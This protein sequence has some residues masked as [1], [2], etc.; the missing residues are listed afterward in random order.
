MP[1]KR[2]STS[3]TALYKATQAIELR[4]S[5]DE[6]LEGVLR[7]AQTL[8]EFEHAAILVFDSN[9]R[10]LVVEKALGYGDRLPQTLGR[11]FSL[12]EGLCGWAARHRRPVC[13]GD[14]T[15]D[16]R[17]LPGLEKAR[18][19][20]VIPL[21]AGKQVAGVLSVEAHRVDAF[22]SKHVKLLTVLGSQA[23]LAI[24]AWK[25]R[26]Q[27]REKVLE[28]NALFRVSQLASSHD[29]LPA[30]LQAIL[31]ISQ[32]IIPQGNCAVLLVD[33]SQECLRVKA[34]VNYRK[35]VENLVIPLG[36]GVTGRCA[37]LGEAIVVDEVSRDRDYIPGLAHAQSEIAMPLRVEGR[38]IGVLNAESTQSGAFGETQIRIL[39][40]IAQQAAVVLRTAQL[41]EETRRL[42]ITDPLT[43]LANRR[44][45]LSDLKANL[46]RASRYQEQLAVVFIDLDNFKSINDRFG[47]PT[48]DLTL[49]AV[50]RCLAESLRDSDLV[51]RIGG[52]EFAIILLNADVQLALKIT[53]RVRTHVQSL[54]LRAEEGEPI[55]VTL[56]AGI[57]FYPED[58]D[59]VNLLLQRADEALY[60]A[61]RMGR[62]QVVVS[63]RDL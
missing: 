22:Q 18:S 12:D 5:I 25:D 15:K 40:V 29:E 8:V 17:Y 48:G 39:S 16:P 11:R 13:V 50:S 60:Q 24:V 33:S 20:L 46:V 6:I 53:E 35:D 63:G 44:K 41:Y 7:E 38:V 3:L 45:M 32:E 59:S 34:S 37:L 62:N 26:E 19:N 52:E 2:K 49:Q 4:D 21:V 1:P 47:H 51:S 36:R 61:K 57:A 58:G 42:A 27:F 54:H 28:L 9:R 30:T 31:E 10:Q 43:G 56:S 55:Q 14:V 23:A